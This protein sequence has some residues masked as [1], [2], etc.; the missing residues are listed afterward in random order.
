VTEEASPAISVVWLGI[1]AS[2]AVVSA[3]GC[4]SDSALAES[5]E[6][7]DRFARA[8][9]I[10]GLATPA[11]LV[12]IPAGRFL[13]GSTRLDATFG[14]R[15]PYDDMEI[16]QRNIWLDAYAIDRDEV[17]V[18]RYLRWWLGLDQERSREWPPWLAETG[19]VPDRFSVC[20]VS[21]GEFLG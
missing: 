2:I 14:L 4:V 3:M 13:M 8:E 16:P 17:S 5:D 7:K 20:A 15:T 1:V 9:A 19:A 21:V 11:P 6:T 12:M 10:A 18:S